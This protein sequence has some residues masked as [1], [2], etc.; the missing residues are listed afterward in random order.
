MTRRQ[1]ASAT[2]SPASGRDSRPRPKLALIPGGLNR[3]SLVLVA[4]GELD[5]LRMEQLQARVDR[6]VTAQAAR[7]EARSAMRFLRNGS[8]AAVGVCLVELARLAEA[9]AVRALHMHVPP[10]G[11]VDDAQERV[12]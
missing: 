4:Q 6:L 8:L 2:R 11:P 9:E 7:Q 12:A 3:P 1:T 5:E 10:V